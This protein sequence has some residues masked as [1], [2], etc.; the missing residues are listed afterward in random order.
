MALRGG[1]ELAQVVHLPEAH[2]EV[3]ADAERERDDVL[4][5]LWTGVA[6]EARMDRGG[7]L[8]GGPEAVA[9][10]EFLQARRE[11]VSQR[12]AEELAVLGEHAV[13]VQVAV[14]AE[15]GDDLKGVHR[16]LQCARHALA[17][18]GAVAQERLQ[19]L[20]RVAARLL[21]APVGMREQRGGHD[22]PLGVRV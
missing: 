1:P 2:P 6:H 13:P 12:G 18:V 5:Q 7:G 14:G 16:V 19:D 21:E 3:P 8:D 4:R 11:V 22:F 15:V 17:A 10:A 20:R 9:H